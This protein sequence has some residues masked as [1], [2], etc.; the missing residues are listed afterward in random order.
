[1]NIVFSC[2][3]ETDVW[4]KISYIKKFILIDHLCP[5]LLHHSFHSGFQTTHKKLQKYNLF[6]SIKKYFIRNEHKLSKNRHIIE[7]INHNIQNITG[8]AQRKM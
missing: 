2:L 3:V 4:R 8:I 5:G 7:Y 6:N 1:M